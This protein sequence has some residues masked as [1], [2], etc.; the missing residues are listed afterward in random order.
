MTK[1]NVVDFIGDSIC[2]L[3]ICYES[4]TFIQHPIKW[5]VFLYTIL[6]C[7]IFIN[8]NISSQGTS[9]GNYRIFQSLKTVR[10]GPACRVHKNSEI[11]YLEEKNNS[12]Q[13]NRC[14]FL[15]FSFH[16]AFPILLFIH[17][18]LF[19]SNSVPLPLATGL[20]KKSKNW[21]TTFWK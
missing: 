13:K 4:T 17:F 6:S 21:N 1:K 10:Q 8:I 7:S 11:A 19:V 12:L 18:F 16:S 3:K 14:Y 15:P 5:R 9:A 2:V 20:K